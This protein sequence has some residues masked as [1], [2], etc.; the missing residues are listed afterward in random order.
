MMKKILA[1]LSST[2]TMAFLMIV[3]TI[4]LALATFVENDFG[5]QTARSIIYN[6]KWFE[7]L[8]FLALVNIVLVTFAHKTYKKPAIFL[9]HMAFAM[10]IAGAGLT[11]Y[12]GFEGTMQIR[13]NEQSTI[14]YTTEKYITI[15]AQFGEHYKNISRKVILNPLSKRNFKERIK[16]A[17]REIEIKLLSYRPVTAHNGSV[18]TDIEE[19]VFNIT[20]G[21]VSE[22]HSYRTQQGTVGN[23]TYIELN[24]ILLKIYY[25]IKKKELPFAIRLNDFILERYPGSSSPSWFESRVMIIEDNIVFPEF[26]IYMNHVLKHKGY[27]FFQASYDDDEKGTIL[28][29][30]YDKAGVPITYAGYLLMVAGMIFGLFGRRSRF[31]FILKESD[32]IHKN[33]R[34]LSVTFLIFTLFSFSVLG[35][36][37]D[38]PQI[39]K[40]HAMRFGSILLQDNDGRIKPL[41]TLSSEVLRKIARKNDFKGLS[42][43]EVFLGMLVYPVLWQNEPLIKVGHGK[44]N[45]ILGEKGKLI[46]FSSFFNEST[47]AYILGEYVRNAN[48]KK[49]ASRSKFENELIRADERLNVFYLACSGIMLTAF[50]QKNDP[51]RKW[52]HPA[53]AKNAFNSEDSV[54]V[55]NII[56]YYISKVKEAAGSGN[57]TDADDLVNAIKA[58]QSA[59]GKDV[60]PSKTRIKAEILYNRYHPF[61]KISNIYGF[62]G[63]LLLLIQFAGIFFIRIKLKWPQYVACGIIGI[64]FLFHTLT[65]AA[66]WYISGHAPWSN[67]Y[68]ALTFIAWASV[69]G[70]IIFSS[71][72][73]VTLSVAAILAWMALHAAHLS[74]MDPEITT[75]VPVLKS[76]WLILHVA[77]ITASY[78][79]LGIGALLAPINLMIMAL[80]NKKNFKRIDLTISELSNII[81][82]SLISGLY[83]LAIGTFLGAVWAN[84]SWGRYWGWDPKETW[85]LITIVVYAFISHMRLVPGLKSRYAFNLMALLGFGSV[86]MTYFGVN[87]YLSGLHS[88][89][90]G[91]ALPI[92]PFFYYTII[93]IT[94]LAILS[95][96]RQYMLGKTMQN[97]SL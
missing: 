78:G 48:Q 2:S 10:I 33:K 96:T 74:W 65:L 15:E 49:P 47:G 67:G 22:T 91:D 61:E 97:T 89:A 92:P 37:P 1:F 69:L 90:Q 8:L 45:E 7:L 86:I 85:S 72:T 54:F 57:W 68:E 38:M 27:R 5:P 88:Y 64:A 56:P 6:A 95:Y 83:L 77:V 25:G 46:P 75:L 26:R 16:T 81:E 11:R 35:N 29:V 19:L 3:F 32:R 4:S 87:Y 43:D 34:A 55:Q 42:P 79:F 80:Q 20:S 30:N 28:S 23:T 84:E 60:M 18:Q 73:P 52:Y 70:G 50:P 51:D 53:N 21:A 31:R 41:N 36:Q 76:Y 82:I 40:E 44:I 17:D 71:K 12:F 14:F 94:I 39:D 13:E 66:R 9:F 24:G 63:F 58:F 62:T 93:S 59:F